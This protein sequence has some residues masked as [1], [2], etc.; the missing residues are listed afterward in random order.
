MSAADP[1][2]GA[3]KPHSVAI[4]GATGSLAKTG[5][6][7]LQ[8]LIS[9]GFSGAIYPVNPSA[10]S[11]QGLLAYPDLLSTPTCAELVILAVPAPNISAIVEQGLQRGV[12]GFICITAGFA[13]LGAV[14]QIE[15]EILVRSIRA[16]GARLIGPNSNGVFLAS[17]NLNV[18]GMTAIPRGPIGVITQSG[19]IGH[20]FVRMARSRGVG[21]SAI[22]SI[23]NAA[24]VTAAELIEVLTKDAQTAAIC[25]YLEGFPRNEGERLLAVAQEFGHQKPILAVMAGHTEVGRRA[26]ASHTGMLAT[27]G[28]GLD[29]ILH[30]AGVIRVG[31]VDDAFDL[32]RALAH[33]RLPA[34][35]TG[36]VILADSGGPASM[37][38]DRL[39]ELGVGVPE[40]AASTQSQLRALV[41]SWGS[42]RN[43]VDFAG[44]AEADPS[45]IPSALKACLAD[46][47]VGAALV[48]GHFGGYGDLTGG[49][50]D[51]EEL[52]AAN[53][54]TSI[55]VAFAKPVVVH[56][57]NAR[58]PRPALEALERG[59]VCA[60][61][62]VT[63]SCE[64]VWG[65]F[66]QSRIRSAPTRLAGPVGET[67]M[68]LASISGTVDRVSLSEPEA[69]RLLANAGIQTP[70]WTV[71]LAEEEAGAA[72]DSLHAL[73]LA[74]KVISPDIAHKSDVGGVV[75]NIRSAQ[76]A[77]VAYRQITRSCAEHLPDADVLGVLFTPMLSG[78][79]ELAAGYMTDSQVGPLVMV[80][81][82]GLLI[83]LIADV[84]MRPASVLLAGGRPCATEML[85]ELR[86]WPL[87]TGLRGLPS[88][89]VEPVVD[90]LLALAHLQSKE[91]LIAEVDLNPI[92]AGPSSTAIA[93]VRVVMYAPSA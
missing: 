19:N 13:E 1:L 45:A 70:E 62:T 9:E 24:D 87:F 26:V 77:R 63:R 49:L 90:L 79:I 81:L 21:I 50:H 22:L 71:A 40:L 14:G 27:S 12:R 56:S 28:R 17:S 11:I 54:I 68:A 2:W 84:S 34:Q 64:A 30:A 15:Q 42:L 7:R 41:P 46:D 51:A 16:A 6:R 8:S 69:R 66:E 74:A 52:A 37:A 32:A 18:T 93:D 10:D 92:L 31:D 85:H 88:I 39:D 55:S 76:E 20:A 47:A 23:G 78:T 5:G 65:L 4:V 86:G 3:L 44:L 61:E 80:G 35:N 75:L 33:D 38:A 83:E 72:F 59:G 82:G 36:V 60:Y 91:P 73:A 89:S 58:E 29:S 43:P 25:L 57:I 67:A 48:V 53:E